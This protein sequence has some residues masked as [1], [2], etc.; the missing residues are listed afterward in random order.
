MQLIAKTA[1]LYSY[2]DEKPIIANDP[3]GLIAHIGLACGVAGMRTGAY[4]RNGFWICHCWDKCNDET[5]WLER[6]TGVACSLDNS[7]I[8]HD[9]ANDICSNMCNSLKRCP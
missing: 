4:S 1:C 3:M 5:C 6:D 8:G 9:R 7:S 2:A